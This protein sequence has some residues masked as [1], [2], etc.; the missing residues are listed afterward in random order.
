MQDPTRIYNCDES[1]FPLAG[2][3]E[4]VLASRGCKTVYQISNSDRRQLTVLACMSASGD[5]VPPMLIFPGARFKYDPLNGAP[6]ERCVG[7]MGGSTPIFLL[8]GWQED[9]I[10]RCLVPGRPCIAC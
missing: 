7:R 8:N 5:Y 1:G 6:E 9:Q 10:S 2:K 4:K 3:T